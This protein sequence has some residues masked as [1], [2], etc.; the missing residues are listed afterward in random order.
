[1]PT[2]FI[3]VIV[4]A[5]KNFW[6]DIWLSTVTVV[7]FVLAITL[8]GILSGV[9]VVTD[10]AI[11]VLR[12]K[13]D[14][15]V[16]FKPKTSE[17]LVQ[18]L[19]V[20]LEALPETASVSYLSAEDNLNAFKDIHADEESIIEGTNALSSNPFGPSLKIQSRSLDE[21]PQ[22]SKVLQDDAYAPSI[23]S[24]GKTLESNQEAIKQLSRFTE[25][26]NRFS[27]AL[28]AI[29]SLIAIFVVMNTMRIAMYSHRE[30]IGIMKLV[31]ASNWFVRG[32]FIIESILIGV[33]ASA[34]S[35]M[36]LLG[37]ISLLSG[38]FMNL[39]EGTNVNMSAYFMA[40]FV[41]IFWVPLIG[42]IALSMVSAGIAVGRYLRV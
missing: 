15:I 8:V 30:E 9:K 42:A 25:N 27:L 11:T 36:I 13:V 35:A 28:T 33:L 17:K 19:K 5:V 32:P 14:V 2:S 18:E 34:I 6:R 3:R 39:F 29:F 1:M 20:K 4:F 41:T 16:T 26:V 12:S 21:Y 38:W 7:I 31:G 37:S 10:Q 23:V 22:I 24:G 40:N